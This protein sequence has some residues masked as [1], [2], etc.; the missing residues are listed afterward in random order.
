VAGTETRFSGLVSKTAVKNCR[1]GLCHKI[2][3]EALILL[4]QPCSFLR[5]G[6]F[7]HGYVSKRVESTVI[8]RIPGGIN[9]TLHFMVPREKV[10]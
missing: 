6:T 3:L 7:G 2:F 4:L 8:G 9:G 10:S 5:K 1:I